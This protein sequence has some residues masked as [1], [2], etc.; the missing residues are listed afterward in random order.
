MKI[1]KCLGQAVKDLRGRRRRKS[2]HIATVATDAV[3]HF[4]QKNVGH[5]YRKTKKVI[6]CLPIKISHCV[7][8]TWLWKILVELDDKA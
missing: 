7:L 2:N 3:E 5:S 1:D 6:T 8:I 4:E